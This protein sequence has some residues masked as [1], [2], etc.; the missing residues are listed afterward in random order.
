MQ[1]QT[2]FFVARYPERDDW[3]RREGDNGSDGMLLLN[4]KADLSSLKPKI[5]LCI[6]KQAI[7][8]NCLYH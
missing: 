3:G 2:P 4:G 5:Y 7:G 1:M 8:E 6:T